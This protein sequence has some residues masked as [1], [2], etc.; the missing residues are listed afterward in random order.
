MRGMRRWIAGAA[1]GTALV[2]GGCKGSPETEQRPSEARMLVE[3][4]QATLLDVRTVQEFNEGHVDGAVNIPIQVLKERL[5][6]LPKDKP[7]VVYCHSGRRS[8]EAKRLLDANGFTR[9]I[10][11]GPMPDWK[12]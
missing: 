2:L 10:D 11:I 1:I 5:N 8:A 4:G 12:K 6:E 9:V 3:Q 7:V